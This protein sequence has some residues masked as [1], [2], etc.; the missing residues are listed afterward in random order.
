MKGTTEHPAP[1]QEPRTGGKRIQPPKNNP[2]M[3][4]QHNDSEMNGSEQTTPA[5]TWRRSHGK[6]EGNGNRCV[7][8]RKKEKIN[9][10]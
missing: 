8:E 6:W 4:I 5:K 9:V 2:N 3:A 10:R 1:K 7:N